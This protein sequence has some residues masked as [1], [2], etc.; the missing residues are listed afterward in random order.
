MVYFLWHPLPRSHTSISQTNEVSISSWASPKMINTSRMTSSSKSPVRNFQRP[1]SM[2]LRMRGSWNTSIH[3]RYLKF[4]TWVKI[5]I[6]WWSI[7]S[8]ITPSSKYPVRNLQSPPSMTSRMR[9][10]W[11]TSNHARELK[12]GTQVKI[13]MSWQPLISRRCLEGLMAHMG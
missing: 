11:G 12:F 2:T 4:C 1:P 10:S 8:T 9:C 6:S 5:H 3:T 13:V 7:M